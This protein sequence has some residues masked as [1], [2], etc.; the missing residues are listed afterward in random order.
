MQLEKAQEALHE[1]Q[2][3]RQAL[4]REKTAL[5]QN[6]AVTQTELRGKE[7]VARHGETRLHEEKLALQARAEAAEERCHE[8][9]ARRDALQADRARLQDTYNALLEERNRLEDRLTNLTT[10][11]RGLEELAL[12]VNA[13]TRGGGGMGKSSGVGERGAYGNSLGGAS[14]GYTPQGVLPPGSEHAT[15][16][17]A[18][19]GLAALHAAS[20]TLPTRPFGREPESRSPPSWRTTAATSRIASTPPGAPPGPATVSWGAEDVAYSSKD[21]GYAARD[22]AA[23]RELSAQRGVPS[24]TLELLDP[25]EAEFRRI[26]KN[27]DGVITAEEWA[28]SRAGR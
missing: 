9:N 20:T 23:A 14:E 15:G 16:G 3:E 5:A 2:N 11:K 25:R 22:L 1:V 13:I 28:A 4:Q 6:L 10:E 26:D 12:Y 27:G 19:H 8:S 18:P 21:V 7:V 24:S 17:G